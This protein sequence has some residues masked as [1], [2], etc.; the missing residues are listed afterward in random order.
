MF[1]APRRRCDSIS[2]AN[3]TPRIANRSR[4]VCSGS[5]DDRLLEGCRSGAEPPGQDRRGVPLALAHRCAFRPNKRVQ[6]RHGHCSVRAVRLAVAIAVVVGLQQVACTNSAAGDPG[7]DAGADQGA[8]GAGGAQGGGH[9]Y[10]DFP[11]DYGSWCEPATHQGGLLRLFAGLRR[12][13]RVRRRRNG[14]VRRRCGVRA[15]RERVRR[16]GHACVPSGGNVRI[17]PLRVRQY[18]MEQPGATVEDGGERRLRALCARG[19]RGRSAFQDRDRARSARPG[20]TLPCWI[21]VAGAGQSWFFW[22]V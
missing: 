8:A 9:C 21:C 11:C 15:G 19:R 3:P 2:S 16:P 1:V 14:T 5:R 18:G 10:V 7:R 4:L 13:H 22:R 17:R 20:V 6:G 12:R